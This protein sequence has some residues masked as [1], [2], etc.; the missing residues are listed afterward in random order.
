M[1]KPDLAGRTMKE[2]VIFKRLSPT[3]KPKEVVKEKLAEQERK[4]VEHIRES[5]NKKIFGDY[6]ADADNNDGVF[7]AKRKSG[8]KNEPVEIEEFLELIH[9]IVENDI[10]EIVVSKKNRVTRIA[11][12][13]VAI[14]EY[15]AACIKGLTG[16]YW[17]PDIYTV[18]EDEYLKSYS[19]LDEVSTAELLDALLGFHSDQESANSDAR[20]TQKTV[21]HRSEVYRPTGKSPGAI[22]T[23]RIILGDENSYYYL[24][25]DEEEFARAIGI[26]NSLAEDDGRTTYQ[27]GK[28]HGFSSNPGIK[29]DAIERNAWK[30]YQAYH[31]A[32]VLDEFEVPD[33][34]AEFE[35]LLEKQGHDL[36]DVLEHSPADLVEPL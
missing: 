21:D 18:E 29:T 24:P 11:V 25:E 8:R 31:S 23:N 4:C 5:G 22:N 15:L 13:G 34:P 27:I 14:R 12:V 20:S 28:D 7:T 1:G 3:G 35:A 33:C 26:L 10:Q 36:E 30:F 16:E 32:R 6:D 2:V 9:F 19:N 17:K